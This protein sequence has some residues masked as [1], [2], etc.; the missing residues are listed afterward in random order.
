MHISCRP[1][2][3]FLCYIYCSQALCLPVAWSWHKIALSSDPV[4]VSCWPRAQSCTLPSI[5]M[6]KASTPHIF[7]LY[8]R[9]LCSL[10][11]SGWILPRIRNLVLIIS[12]CWALEH[13][14][15][16]SSTTAMRANG[17]L[18]YQEANSFQSTRSPAPQWV[19]GKAQLSNNRG[20]KLVNSSG[21][22]RALPASWLPSTGAALRRA[23]HKEA[24]CP[25]RGHSN[26]VP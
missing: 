25:S 20:T 14:A 26:Y 24:S 16:S 11:R 12:S 13:R 15:F 23:Q 21:I 7:L 2:M 3:S 5:F 19:L 6:Q 1:C 4:S 22:E 17:W 10:G 18:C 9:A 8:S